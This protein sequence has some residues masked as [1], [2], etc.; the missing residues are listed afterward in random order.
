METHESPLSKALF[1]WFLVVAPVG[2]YVV[3]E[4]VF[5]PDKR[6]DSVLSSAEWGI[7]TGFLIIMSIFFLLRDLPR[8]TIRPKLGMSR[9]LAGFLI[10]CLFAAYL[11]SIRILELAH[12]PRDPAGALTAFVVWQWG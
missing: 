5:V 9:L 4:H 12:E 11:V 8:V 1:E 3:S 6:T 2:V 10:L 7:A